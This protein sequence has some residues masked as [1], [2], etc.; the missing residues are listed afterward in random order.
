M[1]LLQKVK[2][3]N[4]M[5]WNYSYYS[6]LLSLL[7]FCNCSIYQNKL[8]K[9]VSCLKEKIDIGFW[10]PKEG[11]EA[12]NYKAHDTTIALIEIRF[13]SGFSDSI[14]V[15]MNDNVIQK[16]YAETDPVT[17]ISNLSVNYNYSEEKKLPILKVY[18]KT[19]NRCF[20]IQI[21]KGWRYL[22][23]SYNEKGWILIYSNYET[24]P[25]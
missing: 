7:L 22:D 24:V 2:K 8:N 15:Y 20:E 23:V 16:G 19:E 21:L 10:V 25:E 17:S 9:N 4:R 6:I 13:C 18:N 11:E 5:K 12:R 14:V 3:I 1:K